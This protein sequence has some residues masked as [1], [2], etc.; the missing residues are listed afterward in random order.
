MT[1][2]A[3]QEER[4]ECLKSGMQDHITKPIKPDLFYQT[5]ARWLT[6]AVAR[7]MEEK[8]AAPQDLDGAPIEIPGF[9]TA[10]TM[11][12]L[13]GD[14]ELYHRVLEM[15]L[16]SLA[17]ALVRFNAAVEACDPV[18]TK[19]AVHS[20]RGMAAN[21]GAV[22]LSSCAADLEKMLGERRERPEQLT[23]F[24]ALVEQTLHLVEQGLAERKAA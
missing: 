16:P 1:A 24:R 7:A 9:D 23:T 15:L 13:S 20:V 18:A 3:S 14:V 21:V 11:D 5:L 19:S 12:R 8:S 6:P 2:H 22:A 4:E 10:D 17:D